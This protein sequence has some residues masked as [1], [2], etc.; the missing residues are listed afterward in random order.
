MERAPLPPHRNRLHAAAAQATTPRRCA[1]RR[2][3]GC[4]T[5]VGPILHMQQ[6][7]GAAGGWPH[8]VVP[9]GGGRRKEAASAP[10]RPPTST[11]IT[12][13]RARRALASSGEVCR[14]L[15]RAAAWTAAPGRVSAPGCGSPA[16]VTGLTIVA[17]SASCAPCQSGRPWATTSMHRASLT[18]T[19]MFMSATRTLRATCA[20]PSRQ[21]RATACSSG[22]ARDAKTPDVAHAERWS[23][24]GSRRPRQRQTRGRGSG[25]RRRHSKSTWRCS[26]GR[27][28]AADVGRAVRARPAWGP[29]CE[30]SRARGRGVEVRKVCLERAHHKR[31][32]QLAASHAGGCRRAGGAAHSAWPRRPS[33]V[34]FPHTPFYSQYERGPSAAAATAYIGAGGLLGWPEVGWTQR[35]TRRAS[36]HLAGPHARPVR[37]QQRRRCRGGARHSS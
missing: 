35:R 4:R 13:R 34:F 16:R 29:A 18:G 7:G 9:G 30:S 3:L 25:R 26:G 20:P 28:T 12:T 15:R 24:S 19:S 10:K 5:S 8:G 11:P 1:S 27:A 31:P 6:P 37:R 14:R 21:T 33:Q 36:V 23:P 17:S 22:K 2:Q 32:Q